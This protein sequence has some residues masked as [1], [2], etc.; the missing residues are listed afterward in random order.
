[1]R[2]IGAIAGYVGGIVIF[3][4]VLVGGI[5]FAQLQPASASQPLNIPVSSQGEETAE[6]TSNSSDSTSP[7][8]PQ[9]QPALASELP[10]TGVKDNI[11][12]IL[13]L[14]VMTASVFAYIRSRRSVLTL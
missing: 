12:S 9:S 2:R 5:R 7:P 13:G 3:G 10:Q 11:I 4:G 1:M 8:S 14:G 6:E